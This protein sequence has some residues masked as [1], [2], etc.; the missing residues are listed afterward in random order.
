MRPIR[1]FISLLLAT[2][3]LSTNAAPM[4]DDVHVWLQRMTNAVH[5]LS[6][7]GIFVVLHNAQLESMQISHTVDNAGEK[8][9]LVSLNGVAREVFR[10]NASVTCIAPDAKSVSIGNRVVAQGFRSV[11]SVDI[12]QLS[13]VYNFHL[14]GDDRVAGRPVRIV[15]IIPKDAYRY[16]YRLYL[17]RE[18]A[19]PLKTDMLN[20]SGV[21]ISQSMFTQLQVHTSSRE[22]DEISLDGKEYYQWVQQKPVRTISDQQFSG[23]SFNDLPKGFHVTLHSKRN[24]GKQ[25]EDIDHFVLSDGLAS[26][27][28]YVEAAVDVGLQGSSTMGT[29]NAFGDTISGHQV[30][31]VGEVPAI[32]VERI[33]KSLR[34]SQQ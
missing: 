30:T 26:L 6:Y 12:S 24:S 15:A 5:S 22:I 23:W 33:A 25:A 34:F 17:D 13:D 28:V 32:T 9:R 2:V 29:V 10:D 19:L 7:D 18:H 31:A 16:G 20:V 1:F 3:S 14:L 21:P 8:E 11:F 27:S 4:A